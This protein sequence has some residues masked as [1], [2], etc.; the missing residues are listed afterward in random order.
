[1]TGPTGHSRG[2]AINPQDQHRGIAAIGG[3]FML[4]LIAYNLVRIPKLIPPEHEV[5]AD[6]GD[7]TVL[8]LTI[9]L[10][11]HI[12]PCDEESARCRASSRPS[13]P[14]VVPRALP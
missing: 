14:N 2:V 8:G 3:D 9:A 7:A 6:S 5:A 13:P 1:M 12:S 11:T 10:R 4:S